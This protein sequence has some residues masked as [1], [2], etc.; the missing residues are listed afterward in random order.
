MI[1]SRL[2]AEFDD[3]N[4]PA[5]ITKVTSGEPTRYWHRT[6]G[7]DGPGNVPRSPNVSAAAVRRKRRADPR[8][9]GDVTGTQRTAA[10]RCPDVDN[11]YVRAGGRSRATSAWSPVTTSACYR[12]IAHDPLRYWKR[13]PG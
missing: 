10:M 3:R 5:A 1:T 13:T 8:A 12:H 4:N 9:P 11:G 6:L 2:T 7:A